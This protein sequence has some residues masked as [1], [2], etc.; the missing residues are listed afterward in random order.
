MLSYA[1]QPET[2]KLLYGARHLLDPDMIP[3]MPKT[4]SVCAAKGGTAAFQLL[5]ND[6]GGDYTVR[7]SGQTSLS[8]L[9]QLNTYRVEVCSEFP[10]TLSIEEY[11]TDDDLLRRADAL[12]SSPN[13]DFHPDE[14]AGIWIEFDIPENADA[15]IYRDKVNIYSS[16]MFG[17]EEKTACLEYEL[18][19]YGHVEKKLS[20]TDFH[21]D[22]W[23]HNTSIA[24]YAEVPLWSG[25][26][27]ELIE[28]YVSVLARLGQKAVTL[29]VS[30]APWNGQW[31]HLDK[32]SSSTLYEY[33]IID[34]YREADGSFSYDYSAMDR[35]IGLCAEYGI[36]E[37]I[38]VYGLV[39]VWCDLRGGFGSLCPEY[40]DG[41]KIKFY[42][43]ADGCY[44]YMDRADDIDGYVAAL[45]DHFVEC[46][47]IEKVRVVADEPA[48]PDL[49]EI[50]IGHL[51]KIAPEFKLKAALNNTGF[52][53][54]FGSEISDFVP[55]LEVWSKENDKLAS[56]KNTMPGKRFL[57]YIC[58]QPPYPNTFIK[59][60]LC[61]TL[62]LGVLS[63]YMETDGF[64]R[65]A[66]CEWTKEP[67]RDMRYFGWAA[68]DLNFVYPQKNGA[69]LL[70]LRYKALYRALELNM[71]LRELKK[72]A[73][74]KTVEKAFSF[75]MRKRDLSGFFIEGTR[76]PAPAEELYSSEYADYDAMKRFVLEKLSQ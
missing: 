73:D 34:T 65:W 47:L 62:Y 29:I 9:G 8:A 3:D 40:P 53:E 42:D 15:G 27:F 59:S 31:C 5:I 46:G 17:A 4:I 2:Y 72:T 11:I 38:S 35:Y 7:K 37:E 21:L 51:K 70:S 14:I 57:W 56:Y 20:D 19:V 49:Y 43:K 58:N 55:N 39:N 12:L 74:K 25:E 71:L 66:L 54:R 48:F 41:V 22:I 44:K 67:R 6:D 32:R 30:D 1:L 50:S 18:T 61:E 68:G 45:R 36:S 63:A 76:D 60:P 26:H 33:S 10:C 13:A 24:R 52:I 75:V 69:P 16:K 23:Q 64:L 28:K